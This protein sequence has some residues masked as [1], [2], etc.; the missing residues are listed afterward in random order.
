MHCR[1][2][3]WRWW[4]GFLSSFQV[5]EH[6]LNRLPS[7]FIKRTAFPK[8]IDWLIFILFFI[9]WV[10]RVLK[11]FARKREFLMMQHRKKKSWCI[12]LFFGNKHVLQ[13]NCLG[14]IWVEW[15][16]IELIVLI[17][18]IAVLIIHAKKK[19]SPWYFYL[20]YNVNKHVL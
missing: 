14:K 18:I 2:C 16:A 1:R 12:Y 10:E 9:F 6:S 7:T 19:Y 17:I 8:L 3:T 13:N 5:L 11:I 4:V 20:F 15:T